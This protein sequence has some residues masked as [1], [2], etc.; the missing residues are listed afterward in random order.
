MPKDKKKAKAGSREKGVARSAAEEE[1]PRAKKEKK[2]KKGT[3]QK[4]TVSLLAPDQPPTAQLDPATGILAIALP[5][6][7]KGEKGERGPAGPPGERGPKGETGS[8]GPQGPVGPQ[9]PQGAR[10]EA[11]PRGEQGPRGEP[12]PAG[13]RGEPALG[14]R[15][16]GGAS[17]GSG[18]LVVAADG[19]L[20]Y[21]RNGTRY[22]VQLTPEAS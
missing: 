16:E 4:V 10:G 20:H 5:A 8:T 17:V 14:I 12:G 6:G 3:I 19:S 1:A 18:T 7:Q 21:V 9:G 2:P 11:G 13:P 15:Y 22:T